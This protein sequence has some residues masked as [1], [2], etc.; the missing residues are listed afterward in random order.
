M[1]IVSRTLTKLANRDDIAPGLKRWRVDGVDGKGRQWVHGPFLG[2]QVNAEAIRDSAWTQQQ[3]EQA[4]ED[5]GL[6]FI[7]N[8]GDPE[9]FA[10]EDLSLNEWRRRV[11]RR[12]WKADIDQDRQFL[13]RVAPYIAGFTA[14]QIAG[15][16]G[17]T[18]ARAQLGIDKAVDL[19]DNV[20]PA[21][22]AVDDQAEDV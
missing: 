8:G 22:Q 2:T 21:M 4:D 14:A 17:I 20:C 19:R 16:L 7:E 13:C 18:E 1:P 15:V 11:A 9:S 12:F 6:Q 10:R 3:L 5:E